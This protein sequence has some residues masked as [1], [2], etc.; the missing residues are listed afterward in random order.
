MPERVDDGHV[1]VGAATFALPS[2]VVRQAFKR[3]TFRLR[4]DLKVAIEEVYC[5]GCRK[6]YAKAAGKSCE[7]RESREHLIG[8]P[9]GDQRKRREPDESTLRAANG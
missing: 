6:T 3:G 2:T 9:I 7:A 1:W 8:G 4:R 5:G